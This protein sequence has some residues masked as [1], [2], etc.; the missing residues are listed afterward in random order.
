MI[1]GY[2]KSS[3]GIINYNQGKLFP[4]L[5]IIEQ[6]KIVYEIPVRKKS[7]YENNDSISLLINNDDN[8]DNILLIKKLEQDLHILQEYDQ[9]KKY[10]I[11]LSLV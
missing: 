10:S 7:N 4:T 11:A 5:K 8:F 1:I 9:Y 2:H 3:T 6:A